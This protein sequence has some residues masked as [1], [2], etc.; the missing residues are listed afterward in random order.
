[1]LQKIELDSWLIKERSI[2]FSFTRHHVQPEGHLKLFQIFWHGLFISN[3]YQ[4]ESF[5][6]KRVIW[7]E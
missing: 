3:I 6:K 4:K 5:M 7:D 1:M 2:I